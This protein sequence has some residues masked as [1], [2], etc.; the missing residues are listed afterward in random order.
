MNFDH[1]PELSW[2]LGYPGALALML[3]IV[4]GLYVYF[5]RSGWL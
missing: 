2:H 1:M 3:G 4:G 5:R